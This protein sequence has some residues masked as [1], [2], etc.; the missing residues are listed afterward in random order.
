MKLVKLSAMAI[1]FS[2]L[3]LASLAKESIPN[4]VQEFQL[5]NGLRVFIKEDHRAPLVSVQLWYRVGSADEGTGHTGISHI[6]EHMMFKG[7]QKYGPGQFDK[8]LAEQGGQN[9]AFTSNDMTAY[10]ILLPSDKLNFALDLESDRMANLKMDQQS[11][12]K[13]LQVVIEERRMRT[14]DNPQSL[15]NER[16]YAAAYVASSYHNP[17]IGWM[18]DIK[19]ITRDQAFS[20]Y[21]SWYAP[22]NALLVIVGDVNP[23]EVRQSVEKYFGNIKSKSLPHRVPNITVNPVGKR[24]LVVKAPAK[25]PWMVMGYNVP[26]FK[27]ASQPWEPY[28]LMVLSNILDGGKSARLEKRL[29]RDKQIATQVNCSYSPYNR[30]NILFTL[31]GVPAK[32]ITTR[33]LEEAYLEEISQLQKQLVT[34]K[35]LAR[36]KAQVVATHIYDKDEVAAQAA[37]IGGLEVIGLSWREGEDYPKKIEAVSAEQVRE[38]AKKYLISDR[39]TFANLDPQPMSSEKLEPTIDVRGEQHVR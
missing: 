28:A 21:E 8:I 13:E 30:F 36:V 6:V 11:Y 32:N 10:T 37:E 38:V 35:E 31:Q 25:L 20:W 2:C 24:E 5:K 15:T 26:N 17:V 39:L 23:K 19:Q 3:S 27:T 33:Q 12:N 16:F 9:N 18:D 34:E 1:A 7:T 14:E 4:S 29:V 22:N